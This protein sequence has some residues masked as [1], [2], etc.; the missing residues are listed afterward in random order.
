MLDARVF[1]GLSSAAQDIRKVRTPFGGMQLVIVGDFHQ[2]PS[3]SEGEDKKVHGAGVWAFESAFW[4]RGV[5]LS[6]NLTKVHRQT[7][8]GAY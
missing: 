5:D 3:I 6:F 2:L 1:D 8:L 7:S 4:P